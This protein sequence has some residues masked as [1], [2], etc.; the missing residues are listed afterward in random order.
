MNSC[1]LRDAI[2]REHR[3]RRREHDAFARLSVSKYG[4][5]R[6]IWPSHA[7]WGIIAF[8]WQPAGSGRRPA[9][10]LRSKGTWN[11]YSRRR[12]RARGPEGARV[13]FPAGTDDTTSDARE[14]LAP[15]HFWEKICLGSGEKSPSRISSSFGMRFALVPVPPK[16]ELG[17]LRITLDQR[18]H[19]RRS[20]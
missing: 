17:E 15:R 10:L 11:A 9:M 18:A 13:Q 3:R 5:R 6:S 2:R 20:A 1:D 16:G 12:P 7:R 8:Y 19:P 14:F 4:C